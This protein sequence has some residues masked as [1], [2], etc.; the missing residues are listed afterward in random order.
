MFRKLQ[1]QSLEEKRLLAADV[2]LTDSGELL[3]KGDVQDNVV[4]VA[5]RGS[6]VIVSAD[7]QSHS[8]SSRNVES[9]RFHGDAGNDHFTN[10]TNISS[11]LYGNDG[12]DT[13]V[14]G[15]GNDDLRGGN[16]DD[17]LVGG[18]GN[19]EL[20]GDYGN[21][22]LAGG[23]GDDDVRGWYGDDVLSGGDGNDYLSGY[24]GDDV[25]EGGDGDDV[26]KGHE[27][28]DWLFGQDGDDSVYGW[29]GDDVIDGGNGDD[30]LSG[31]SGN[32]IILG[33]AGNDSLRGHSGRDLLI[34]GKGSDSLQGGSGEDF[35]I[36]G[37]TKDDDDYAA[38]DRVLG[39]WEADKSVD[40]RVDDLL[41]Y[42]RRNVRN[43][44]GKADEM[45]DNRD[46]L[47]LFVLDRRDNFVDG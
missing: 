25:I 40:A 12:S 38:L 46:E 20:H 17:A 31:W 21:D 26:I 37:W 30:Y 7:G 34:G 11:V 15:S 44:D 3:I 19:D 14:G 47:D 23:D 28:A 8:F 16:G 43:N 9:I 22:K 24:K 2:S 29:K 13:L 39:V 10:R 36:T 33:G 42:I 5:N 1:F 18:D 35:V 4:V 6:N 41:G 27:G 45:I 32:D